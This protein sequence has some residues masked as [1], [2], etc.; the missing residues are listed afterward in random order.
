MTLSFEEFPFVTAN[1]K[2]PNGTINISVG[3]VNSS[4][5]DELESFPTFEAE[6][7]E[8]ESGMLESFNA[9]YI[10]A[11]DSEDQLLIPS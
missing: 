4:N 10:E 3:F 9:V 8:G 1:G 11:H 6:T 5:M 2:A 7:F